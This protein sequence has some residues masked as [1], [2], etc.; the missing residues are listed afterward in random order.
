M[1][2]NLE[3]KSNRV[4]LIGAICFVVGGP[5]IYFSNFNQIMLIGVATFLLVAK[6]KTNL[7]KAAVKT[8]TQQIEEGEQK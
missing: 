3:K 6:A 8:K 4:I 2:V 1:N 5:I 7:R